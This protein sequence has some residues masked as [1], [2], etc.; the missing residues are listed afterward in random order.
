MAIPVINAQGMAAYVV[1]PGLGATTPTVAL[2]LAGDQIGC[3]QSFGNIEETRAV[4]EYGC[5]SSDETVKVLGS[6]K[7]GN[8]Q[9][10]LLFDPADVAGQAAL[11]AAFAANTEVT[12]G[13]ELPNR[14]A[15]S[16]TIFAFNAV[17]SSVS[18]GIVMDEAV[19]YDVTVEIASSITELAP[20][21]V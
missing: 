9:I 4:K 12:I 19:T 14:L 18:V 5:M 15:V 16:G 6:I 2:I 7:R 10:G 17:I 1:S 11:K 21:A 8:L 3:P 20:T 13:V